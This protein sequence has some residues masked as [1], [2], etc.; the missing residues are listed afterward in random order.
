[1][2]MFKNTR[3]AK[4]SQSILEYTIILSAVVLGI[5][6]M[7]GRMK[8]SVQNHFNKTAQTADRAADTFQ[9]RMTVDAP[10]AAGSH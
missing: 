7:S 2:M 6:A 3:R 9:E 1:M 10:P 8:E 4:K 5:L